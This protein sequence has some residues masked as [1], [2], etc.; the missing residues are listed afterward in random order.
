MT[1][2]IHGIVRGRNIELAEDLGVAD[3][4][5]VAVQVTLI[6]SPAS[7]PAMS[8]GLAEVYEILGRRHASGHTDTAER[9]NEH[10]P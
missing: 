8:A 1:R 3:G 6:P 5:Q 2:I 10:Q 4:Q 9:H 7:Q